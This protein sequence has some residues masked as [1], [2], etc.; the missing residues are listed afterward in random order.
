MSHLHN[1]KALQAQDR[2]NFVKEF[3]D[4]IPEYHDTSIGKHDDEYEYGNQKG[5]VLQIVTVGD[6][7]IEPAMSLA[8]KRLKDLEEGGDAVV[9]HEMVGAEQLKKDKWKGVLIWLFGFLI[10][11]VG[12]VGDFVALGLTRQSVVTLVGSWA[13][14]VNTMTAK[15]LLNEEVIWM[16]LGSI[17]LIIIGIIFTVLASDEN[18]DEWDLPRLVA[19]YK[20]TEVVIL[21]V[22]LAAIIF[23][24]LSLMWADL[25]ARRR[26]AKKKGLLD[27]GRPKK[28]IKFVYCFTP[29]MVGV[30]SVLFG[31]ATSGLLLPTLVGDNKFTGG[32]ARMHPSG[33]W[34]HFLWLKPAWAPLEMHP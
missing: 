30:Y 20:E 23:V 34:A 5:D 2:R 26:N 1:I 28:F 10:F 3:D 18:Q 11:L 6:V 22:I 15:V 33:V 14:V 21:L 13:L 31:K 9:M 7:E 29:A 27:I 32:V 19:R 25:M 16:D 12:N 17:L 24:G 4:Y 8:E